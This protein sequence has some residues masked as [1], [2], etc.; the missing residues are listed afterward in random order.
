MTDPSLGGAFLL[1]SG[2]VTVAPIDDSI[3]KTFRIRSSVE[4]ALKSQRNQK[5]QRTP[6]NGTVVNDG[7]NVEDPRHKTH[8][9]RK[10]G[11]TVDLLPIVIF[12]LSI[13]LLAPMHRS[14]SSTFI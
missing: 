7:G 4:N 8:E 6:S 3:E 14:V 1:F 13:L 9:D 2:K 12:P 5:K 11:I 10:T